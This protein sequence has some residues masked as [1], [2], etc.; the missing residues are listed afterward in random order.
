MVTGMITWF[1][2]VNIVIA[3]VLFVSGVEVKKIVFYLSLSIA[4]QAM[5]L[6]G[7]LG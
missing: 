6:F 5:T 7:L 4:V 3:I 1:I 2:I